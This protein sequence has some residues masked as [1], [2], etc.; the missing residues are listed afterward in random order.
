MLVLPGL[1]PFSRTLNTTSG[2]LLPHS[3]TEHTIRGWLDTCTPSTLPSSSPPH[4][5]GLPALLSPSAHHSSSSHT[6]WYCNC[7]FT[8]RNSLAYPVFVQ[9][10]HRAISFM[11]ALRN[12][13]RSALLDQRTMGVTLTNIEVP[14]HPDDWYSANHDEKVLYHLTPTLSFTQ[15]YP[16]GGASLGP[17]QWHAL[18]PHTRITRT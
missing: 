11:H 13:L 3:Q 4:V 6:P 10:Q 8:L 17:H 15:L 14:T 7:L 16:A 18:A 5:T 12:G 9:K 1:H 2:S